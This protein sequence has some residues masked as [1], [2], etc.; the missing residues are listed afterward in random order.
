MAYSG[1]MNDYNFKFWLDCQLAGSR[2]IIEDPKTIGKDY[3]EY[4]ITA[5]TQDRINEWYRGR[6]FMYDNTVICGDETT[7]LLEVVDEA[8]R[9]YGVRVI[10]LD[11]LMT[12]MYRDDMTDRRTEYE[13]QGQFSARLAEIA[14]ETGTLILLV[15]HKR[16]ESAGGTDEADDVAGNSQTT[17]YAGVVVSYNRY[18]EKEIKDSPYLEASRKLLVSKNRLYGAVNTSG[19]CL[20][21]DEK[22]RRIWTEQRELI[23]QYGWE[24]VEPVQE[25]DTREIPF[26]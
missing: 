25:I 24:K 21:F 14:Q 12:A 16:K 11:N 26:E 6:V 2:N 19:I 4:L 17:N 23:Y 5:S 10:L 13:R 8:I 3:N 20:Y 22:S 15:A 9:R 18:S 1:E 7:G